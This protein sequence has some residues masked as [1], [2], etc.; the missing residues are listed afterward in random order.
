MTRGRSAIKAMV[1]T[2]RPLGAGSVQLRLDP[3]VPRRAWLEIENPGKKNAFSGKMMAELHDAMEALQHDREFDQ[4]TTLMVQGKSGY[5]CSGADLGVLSGFTREQGLEMS[6]LMQVCL[7]DLRDLPLVSLALIDG[8]AMGGG[9]ELAC[10]CD[11]RIF[12]ADATFQMVQT[13]LGLVPGWGG[14]SRL[15]QIVGRKNAIRILCSAKG[16]S[17]QECLQIGLADVVAEN[18]SSTATAADVFAAP[19]DQGAKYPGAVR[20]AKSLIGVA[21]GAAGMEAALEYERGAFASV[22]QAKENL[23]ALEN[24]RIKR[25]QKQN[26]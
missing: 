21:D 22:W 23:D 19:F 24:I 25:Q 2:L 17:A 4:A 11:F 8:G 13:K 18:G 7:Q 15:V 5:F 12:D 14:G 20:K 16:F 10:S 26:K 9:T 3:T 6:H 1:Q